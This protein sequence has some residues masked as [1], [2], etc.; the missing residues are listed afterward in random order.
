MFIDWCWP[1]SISPLAFGTL[2]RPVPKDDAAKTERA[3]NSMFKGAF[4]TEISTKTKG[5]DADIETSKRV[6]EIA[7]KKDTSMAADLKLTDEEI[8]YLEVPYLPKVRVFR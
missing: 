7:K 5:Q 6:G 4:G 3:K 8:K 2:A 1:H